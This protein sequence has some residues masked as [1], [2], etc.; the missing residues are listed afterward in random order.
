MNKLKRVLAAAG[1]S[2][3]LAV[4]MAGVAAADA[5][6]NVD[7]T[8]GDALGVSG[9]VCGAITSDSSTNYTINGNCSA[10]INTGS[11]S[12][13]SSAGSTGGAGVGGAGTVGTGG[14][15]TGG[16]ASSSSSASS[17]SSVT[18]APDCSTHTTVAAASSAGRGAAVA[19]VDVPKGAVHAG[20]G[21]AAT[22]GTS[23]AS[24]LGLT[25]SVATLGAGVAM[26]KKGL[27]GL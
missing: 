22:S 17:N 2:S 19:Q 23:F 25:G 20:G 24:L 9:N 15:G 27:L 4:S 16:S 21:G 12:A 10:F 5:T 14:A 7:C 13:T 1:T 18:F 26:R 8:S 3:V 11:N 6:S